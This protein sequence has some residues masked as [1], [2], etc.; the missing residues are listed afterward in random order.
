MVLDSVPPSARE[1]ARFSHRMDSVLTYMNQASD[2]LS[3]ENVLKTMAAERFG[4]PGTTGLGTEIVT[5]YIAGLGLDTTRLVIADGSGDSRYNLTSAEAIVA[6]L[7]AMA[8]HEELFPVW[9]NTLPV[10]GVNGTLSRRMKGTPAEAN[11]RAKTGTIQGVSSLSGYVTDA[12][13]EQ[14]VFSI[15]MQNFPRPARAY[16]Q[17]QD[18]ITSFLAGVR[19]S[20]F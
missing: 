15:L 18:R 12:D 6:L 13:G 20:Q 7:A 8:R 10:A 4:P 5:A 14:L 17:V 2:N 9:Y 3:A 1:V 11:V 19:R 16:R